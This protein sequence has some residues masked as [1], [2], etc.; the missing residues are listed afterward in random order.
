MVRKV[1]DLNFKTNTESL[2]NELSFFINIEKKKT[3]KKKKKIVKEHYS[4][5]HI[6][7]GL[8]VALFKELMT[9]YKE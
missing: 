3:D 6:L 7:Y 8:D 9:D 5:D 4:N 2:V 1:N